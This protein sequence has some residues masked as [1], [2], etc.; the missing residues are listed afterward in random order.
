[1]A[2]MRCCRSSLEAALS[3][4]CS[5]N[6]CKAFTVC[7][8]LPWQ[9]MAAESEAL[10][11]ALVAAGAVKILTNLLVS[12]AASAFPTDTITALLSIHFTVACLIS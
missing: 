4:A 12:G 2:L 6:L 3:L 11:P 7:W 1:M 10:R 5:A 9:A 8:V